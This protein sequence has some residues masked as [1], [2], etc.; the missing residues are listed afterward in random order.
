MSYRNR[1]SRRQ[2]RKG[3]QRFLTTVIIIIALMYVMVTWVLPGFI[4]GLGSI[5]DFFKGSQIAETPISENPNLA[6]P[7]LNIPYEATNS[8]KINISGFAASH[9][10][11]KI[12]L[13]DELVETTTAE[14]DGTFLTQNI[15]LVL[16]NNNIFGKTEDEKGKESLPSKTIK[17]IYDNEKP[18]LEIS[19]PPDNHIVLGERKLIVDGRT[20]PNVTVTI[21]GEQA[22]VD[23]EGKFS[24]Q[25]NL[26]DGTNIFT[27]ESKD[28][29][30]NTS[31]IARNVTFNP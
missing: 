5:T 25:F 26:S 2:A 28:I 13:D 29:A 31:I 15:D 30:G 21:N 11:V 19:G 9:S 7:V 10:T 4:G 3:K 24:R 6:P 18:A 23:S 8:A 14:D 20:E 17:L 22:I 27:I 12:Y 16:G 1:S